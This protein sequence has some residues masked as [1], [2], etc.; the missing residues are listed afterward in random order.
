MSLEFRLSQIIEKTLSKIS[1]REDLSGLFQ[2]L[3]SLKDR[4]LQDCDMPPMEI[5]TSDLTS[6]QTSLR[7]Q[8]K[9]NKQ[10][11]RSLQE[12]LSLVLPK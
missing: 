7:F 9:S 4:I 11:L 2:D 8:V 12:S 6:A 5:E 1:A 10:Y 3:D